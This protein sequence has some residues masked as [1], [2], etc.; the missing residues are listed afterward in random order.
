MEQKTRFCIAGL[1]VASLIVMAGCKHKVQT[2]IATAPPLTPSPTA[3][4]TASPATVT[5]GEQVS[6]SWKTTNATTASIDGLGDVAASGTRNVTPS[7]STTYHLMAKGNGGTADAYG[8]VTVTQPPVAAAPAPTVT[9]EQEFTTNVKDVF[10]DYDE[11]NVR[12]SDET[13]LSRDAAFLKVHP[14]MKV[15][16]GGYC[17]ERGSNEYNLA[18]GQDRAVS[19]EKTL[20]ADGINASRIRIVSYGKEKPFCSDATDSCW[21]ENRRAGFSLDR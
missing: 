7:A 21:Q 6:L 5:A 3:S 11:F 1:L 8:R 17:D 12:N 19:A 13:V 9:E 10:F 15:V 20:I 2:P 18:L 14:E 4:L 16:I